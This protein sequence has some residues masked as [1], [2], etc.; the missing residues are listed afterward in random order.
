MIQ[1]MNDWVLVQMDPLPEKHGSILV[2]EDSSANTVRTG[3]VV[4]VGKGRKTEGGYRTPDIAQGERV[5]FFRWNLEHKSG[6]QI[7]T[8]LEGMGEDLG[9]IKA[10]DI[11]FAYPGDQHV[12]VR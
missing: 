5:A 10:A 4:G 7:T 6:K 9:L 1:P 3:L 12:E 8:F 11:L 2:L